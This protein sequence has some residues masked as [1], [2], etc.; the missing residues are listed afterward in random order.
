MEVLGEW[1]VEVL[2]KTGNRIYD[3]GRIPDKIALS[4]FITIPKKYVAKDCE[5]FRTIILRANSAC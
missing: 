1:G 4:V 2:T 5:K 3:T